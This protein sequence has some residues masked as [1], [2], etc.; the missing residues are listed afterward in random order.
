[1]L[2]CKALFNLLSKHLSVSIHQMITLTS[3]M[4]PFWCSQERDWFPVNIVRQS[5]APIHFLPFLVPTYFPTG[6]DWLKKINDKFNEDTQFSIIFFVLLLF[7][8]YQ[9]LAV[10]PL[11]D[12][13][14]CAVPSNE[15]IHRFHEECQVDHCHVIRAVNKNQIFVVVDVE[16]FEMW[17]IPTLTICKF[18]RFPI[19]F[20]KYSKSLSPKYKARNVSN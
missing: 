7:L 6:P 10:I 4:P 13:S 1:M 14:E 9:F 12:C 2:A 18:F 15:P 17:H 19:S 11:N 20:G 3:C 5:V 8:S 16:R